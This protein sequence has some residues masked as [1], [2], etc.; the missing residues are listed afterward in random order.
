MSNDLT[1]TRGVDDLAA[2]LAVAYVVPR[3]NLLPPEVT[4]ARAL[5]RTQIGLGAAL[6]VVLGAIAGVF[7]LSVQK[8]DTAGENLAAEQARTSVLQA[9]QAEYARVPAVLAEVEAAQTARETAMGTDVL[10]YEYLDAIARTYPENVWLGDLT[11]AV[12]AT[13]A[14]TAVSADPL[15]TPGIGTVSFTG[16]SLALPDVAAWLDVLAAT[17]GFADPSLTSATRTE[18]DGRVVVDFTSSATI[19]DQAL[20]H[21]FDR[22][23][24]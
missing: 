6:L 14:A 13:T 19:T 21:R 20:S 22:E 8:A 4:A 17:T 23:A 10:W 1:K 7:L 9:E 3:V 11:A 24:G 16:S 2:T 5:R 12:T 18:L 15:A